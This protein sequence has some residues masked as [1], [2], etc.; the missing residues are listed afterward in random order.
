M[1]IVSFDTTEGPETVRRFYEENGYDSWYLAFVNRDIAS[2]YNVVIRSTK[3]GVDRHG[4]IRFREGY[5][6]G[7]DWET[8]IQELLSA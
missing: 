4:V 1:V 5:G 7:V 2:T 6:H 3:L 8:V